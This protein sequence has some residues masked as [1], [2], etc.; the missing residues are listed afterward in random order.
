M[1]ASP[2]RK[3]DPYAFL[4][5]EIAAAEAAKSAKI[6]KALVPTA[7]NISGLSGFSGSSRSR[8]PSKLAGPPS[9][10]DGD[11][12]TAAAV[13]P[14]VVPS[15]YPGDVPLEW[16]AGTSKLIAMRC[17]R[18][19]KSS[20]WDL[21]VDDARRFVDEWASQCATLGWTT[22]DVFGVNPTAPDDRQDG[23]GLVVLLGGYQM[24]AVEAEKAAV[25]S[26]RSGNMLT[27]Y[28]RKTSG[29]IPV[30]DLPE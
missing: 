30:W 12:C 3:F 17:P 11:P 14:V 23:K 26:Q 24:V 16:R 20:R 1:M 8:Y 28:R 9:R 6:A 22:L 15:V 4:Q 19:F 2:F 18:R 7:A 29:Q 5:D 27:I 25:R 21:L 13:S 10:T